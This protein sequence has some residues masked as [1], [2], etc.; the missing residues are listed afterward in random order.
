VTMT[1]YDGGKVPPQDLFYGEPIPKADGGSL[2]V[3]SKGTLFTRTWHG[4]QSAADMFQLLPRQRFE[5]FEAPA[6]TLP[7]APDQSHHK[8]WLAAC[9]GGP[10][11]SSNFGYAASLTESL[12]LGNVALRTGRKIEWD[13]ENMRAVGCPEADAF[14]RPEYRSG[15][16]L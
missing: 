5:G 13:A 10:M 16:T 1:W 9:K 7:R 3:G 8:E 6:A 11:P 14:I 4:G 15:W 2:V 12:L